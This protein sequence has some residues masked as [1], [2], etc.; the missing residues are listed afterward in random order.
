MA[1]KILGMPEHQVDLGQDCRITVEARP[2]ELMMPRVVEVQR[3]R[4]SQ[5]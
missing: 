2:V 5:I 4:Q 3:D 1:K